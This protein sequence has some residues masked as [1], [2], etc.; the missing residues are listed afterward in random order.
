MDTDSEQMIYVV[1]DDDSSRALLQD[2]FTSV[3]LSVETFASAGEFLDILPLCRRGCIILDVR[4]PGMSGLE[5]QQE[6]ARRSA[7][8]PVIIVTA[9]GD[10][11]MAVR[12]MKAGAFDFIEKPIDNQALLDTVQKALLQS[13]KDA[14]KKAAYA[15]I[16]E[17]LDTLTQRESDVLGL[18]IDGELNKQIAFKLNISQRTVEVHRSN[19]MEKMEAKSPADLVR[20]V[21]TVKRLTGNPL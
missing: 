19:V 2:L 3:D 15:E 8:L 11:A 7:T 21:M 6:L 16:M 12:A 14:V 20:M 4:M 10:T 9:H 18:I 13:A 1:E 17:K 5:L